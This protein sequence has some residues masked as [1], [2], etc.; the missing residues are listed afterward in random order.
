MPSQ[1]TCPGCKQ[2]L[3][4]EEFL[5]ACRSWFA[6]VDCVSYTC[7]HCHSA[8]EARLETGRISHGYTY[9]AGAPHF[10]AMITTALPGLLVETTTNGLELTL[11][12]TTRSVPRC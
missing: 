3:E 1:V 9:A 2:P 10:A 4:A 5:N 6:A 7:P 11:D 8:G 12:G